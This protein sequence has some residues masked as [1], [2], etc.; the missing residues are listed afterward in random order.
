[1]PFFSVIIPTYNRA[2]FIA[3]A[4]Q[5]VLNQTFS[6][7]ELIVVD[8][9]STDNTELIVKKIEDSR[10][11]YVK[12]EKNIERCL[13]RNKGISISKGRY[14]CFLDSDDYHLPH[15]LQILYQEIEKRQFPQALFFTNAW[16]SF[17][18]ETLDERVCPLLIDISVFDYI[19]T[20]TFNPQRMCVHH[21]IIQQ[22][23]FDPEVYVCEDLDLAARIAT[24]YP[25]I[26]IPERTTVYV[27]QK[28]SFTV[29]DARKP[30]K[31]L[32]NYNRIFHKQEL[33][34]KFSGKT[35]RRLKSMCHFH[36]A[37]YYEDRNQ[38]VKMY[39]NVLLSFLLF[40]KG[41]NGRTNK[42][43]MVMMIYHLPFIGHVLK[44]LHT[45]Q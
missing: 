41:Y 18:G 42:I 23:Q 8:D 32:E 36:I 3:K 26:Q 9:A 7:F 35:K 34:N 4:I 30:F 22:F 2:T 21:S 1:M 33:K 45:K 6:D 20:Y 28:D 15:H 44:H 16:N 29:G 19:A 25:V 24:Q 39:Y 17:D 27:Y 14:I 5:S 12:N 38:F 37:R 10:L 13:T 40:P 11:K 31:E 43:M